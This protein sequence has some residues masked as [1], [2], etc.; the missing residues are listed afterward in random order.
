MQQIQ[1]T[2]DPSWTANSYRSEHE[3]LRR[4]ILQQHRN[5]ALA[6]DRCLGNLQRDICSRQLI[7]FAIVS[8]CIVVYVDVTVCNAYV[9]RGIC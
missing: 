7:V 5:L 9:Y 6:P 1:Y 4:T 2:T 8:G 3:G